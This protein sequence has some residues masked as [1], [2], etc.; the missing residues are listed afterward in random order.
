MKNEDEKISE[1]SLKE[2]ADKNYKDY[3]IATLEDRAI[4]DFRDGMLPV[5]R[6]L[7]WTAHTLGI[8]HSH[9]FVKS[10]LIVGACLGKF[11]PHSDV[12]CYKSLVGMSPTRLPVGLIDVAGNWGSMSEPSYAAMRYTE[13]RLSEFSDKVLFDKF[14]L[15]V[16]ESVPNYDGS[17]TEPVVLPALLPIVFINGKYGIATG[18][19][20]HIP[21]ITV[22]SLTKVLIKGF[23]EELTA[24]SLYKEIVFTTTHEGT[25]IEAKGEDDVS[26]RKS[27]FTKTS[28]SVKFKSKMSYDEAK[29]T[30]TVTKFAEVSAMDSLLV[31]LQSLAGVA[32]ARDDSTKNDKHARLTIILKKSS[33]PKSVLRAIKKVLSS[34]ENYALLFTER[35]VDSTG[36]GA[37]R[38]NNLSLTEALNK[39]IAW[40]KELETKACNYWAG[41]AQSQIDYL[42]LLCLAVDNRRLII[43]SLDKECTQKELE[44]W[45]SKKLKIT[46]AEAATIY[47][48]KVKQLRKLERK[49]L[50]A[51]IKQVQAE[52][53]SLLKRAKSP[54]NYIASQI[55]SFQKLFV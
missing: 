32:D 28:G 45:L 44:T 53:D 41:K 12:G 19:T 48:L 13:T 36:Q 37:A 43:E 31:S 5:N 52:K 33:D 35:Y 27:L 6:R 39:W 17:L 30:V 23:K 4:P 18:A 38:L 20:T 1:I 46:E 15:A 26:A 9:K 34:K 29:R 47:D 24:K 11:H 7:L 54:S 42:K 14:Y 2:F 3:G 16:S 55:E 49:E 22:D 50:E 10:A 51:K 21:K 25:E 8:S 40:R